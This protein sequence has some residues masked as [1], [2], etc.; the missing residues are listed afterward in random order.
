MDIS[1]LRCRNHLSFLQ[2]DGGDYAEED[3]ANIAFPNVVEAEITEFV[4]FYSYTYTNTKLI[5]PKSLKTQN[6]SPI[7]PKIIPPHSKIIQHPS[8]LTG[9]H[10]YIPHTYISVPLYPDRYPSHQSI[11]S[12]Q[13]I[14]ERGQASHTTC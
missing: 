12:G 6:P 7:T 2:F 8:P 10:F 5:P 9:I 4:S 14:G 3:G 11:I 1:L 13:E